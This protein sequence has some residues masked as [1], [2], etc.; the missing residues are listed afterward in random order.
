ME[1]YSLDLRKRV[2][3]DCDAGM[4]TVEVA[5]K[6]DVSTSW[7]RSLK[8][9]RR[10][11]GSIEALPPGGGR[12]HKI[13]GQRAERL[14]RMVD[15]KPDLTVDELH[16]RMRIKCCRSTIHE[17]MRRLGLTHKKSLSKPMN[18]K[19]QTSKL[20]ENVGAVA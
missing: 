10:E 9:R 3:A 20:K 12:P 19:D 2:I 14:K 7:V 13:T 6:Y 18:E 4:R 5:E 15:D 16:R 8:Q 1:A 17:T 11:T